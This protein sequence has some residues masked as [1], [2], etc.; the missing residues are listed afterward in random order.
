MPTEKPVHWSVLPPVTL[1]GVGTPL[2][3][4]VD[5]YVSRLAW[6]TGA[7][8]GLI[9]APWQP[10]HGMMPANA[11]SASSFCGPG[12][13]YK[14]A[15]RSIETL[16]GIDTIRCGSF[17][18]LD[19]LLTMKA[20]GR[21]SRLR[22]WCPCCFR[23]WDETTSWELLQW[24]IDLRVTCPI[25][26]C[27]LED[28]CHSCGFKPQRVNSYALRRRCPKCKKHLGHN[29]VITRKPKYVCWVESQLDELVNMCATPGIEPIPGTT[30]ETFIRSLAQQSKKEGLS[31][32]VD[33]LDQLFVL[34]ERRYRG[35]SWRRVGLDVLI[36]A[37][38]LQGITVAQLLS[39]PRES[40][41]LP[42]IGNPLDYRPLDVGHLSSSR[43][44]KAMESCLQTML[45]DDAI[46]YLPHPRLVMREINVSRNL[47]LANLCEAFR[48]Y[49]RCHRDQG[50]PRQIY[51]KQMAFSYIL[52]RANANNRNPFVS[53]DYTRL[54]RGLWRVVDISK[55]EAR[56]MAACVMRCRKLIE[57]SKAKLL[58]LSEQ[59]LF[60]QMR[61]GSMTAWLE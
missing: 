14:Q 49:M 58:E 34:H 25:H 8:K 42:L 1:F 38:A 47:V 26:G 61:L 53:A 13:F 28:A 54:C 35:E 32:A 37:C 17:Y 33:T 39:S 31:R 24:M 21:D 19:Q 50:S 46:S 22:R 56:E 29:G 55:R 40:A 2:V 43:R 5:H 59:E 11:K 16:T 27:D 30:F 36:N 10:S 20:L 4:S 60:A 52:A 9:V 15:I 23:D 18:A 51:L 44:A 3:E 48:H 41:V 57:L 12:R 6:I 45:D 7:T